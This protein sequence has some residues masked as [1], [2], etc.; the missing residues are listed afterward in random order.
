M[1]KLVI[2]NWKANK[3]LAQAEDWLATVKNADLN[4]PN[5]AVM[6]ILAPAMPQVGALSSTI[7]DLGWRLAVQDLSPFPAGSYTGATSVANLHDLGVQY[8]IVGHSERR[9]YFSETAQ[10]VARKVEQALEVGIIPIVCVSEE[11]LNAQ[12][13]ALDESLAKRCIVAYEP[14]SAIGTGHDAPMSDIKAFRSQAE[15]LFGQVPFVYGGSVDPSNVAEHLLVT[16]GVLVGTA[17]LESSEFIHLLKTALG[18]P[19]VAA[20]K[21]QTLF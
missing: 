14:L 1:Q 21:I 3:S 10:D 18:S 15:R 4:L 5:E 20:W 2:A 7:N 17:S 16:D 12:A 19:G 9:Q 11:T 8:A 13:S 6:P